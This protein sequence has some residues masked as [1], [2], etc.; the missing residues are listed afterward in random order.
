M[1]RAWSKWDKDSLRYVYLSND[2]RSG[3]F[4]AEILTKQTN[5][6]AEVKLLSHFNGYDALR[7]S[8]IA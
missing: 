6:H 4:T 7:R 5:D 1:G 2:S 8:H 3:W